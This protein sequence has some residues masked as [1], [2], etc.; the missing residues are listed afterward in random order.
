MEELL[1]RLIGESR[2]H[3]AVAK[4]T[5]DNGMQMFAYPL[6]KRRT[7]V[8]VGVGPDA[9]LT[10]AELLARRGARL[11]AAGSWLPAM[12]NDGS[13]YL[14]RTLD[15]ADDDAHGWHIQLDL[16]LGMLN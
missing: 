5:L 4:S 12:F 10:G 8:A 2:L 7:L 9:S 1:T 6:P 13:L 16:A 15:A 14:V 3:D 11:G